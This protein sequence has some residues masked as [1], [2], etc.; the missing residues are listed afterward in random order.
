MGNLAFL[1]LTLSPA[2]PFSHTLS[3]IHLIDCM[4]FFVMLQTSAKQ[5]TNS[6][7]PQESVS[8]V[9]FAFIPLSLLR[10]HSLALSLSLLLLSLLCG[11]CNR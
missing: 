10:F 5:L 7:M 9:H 1:Q 6:N 3:P 4:R 2:F 8:L 11:E